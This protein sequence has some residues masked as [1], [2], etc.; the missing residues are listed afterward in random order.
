MITCSL[1][2]LREFSYLTDSV[3]RGEYN[4]DPDHMNPLLPESLFSEHIIPELRRIY[5]VRDLHIRTVLLSCFESYVELFDKTILKTVILPQ[6][7][8]TQFRTSL[9]ITHWGHGRCV[10]VAIPARL[11]ERV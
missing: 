7:G 11:A 5:H 4:A 8:F 6:V 2:V 1:P 3:D 10:H 9:E